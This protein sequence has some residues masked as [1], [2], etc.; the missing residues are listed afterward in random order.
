MF[1][2][3]KRI[4]QQLSDKESSEIL[5]KNTSGVLALLADDGYPYAIPMSYVY[6]NNKIYFHGSKT[7]HKIDAM[8]NYNKASFCVIDQDNIIP[9]KYTTYFK[10]VIVFGTIHIIEDEDKIKQAIQLL[11]M[12]YHPHDSKNHRTY[13]I[14]KEWNSLCMMEFSIKHM[15]GKQ[16]IE[17]VK[18]KRSFPVY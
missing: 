8:K 2:K 13:E 6:D 3:M 15:T 12:K 7:G 16:A 5:K 4:K 10:S 1:R 9:V 18:K 11:A 14:T 17:M